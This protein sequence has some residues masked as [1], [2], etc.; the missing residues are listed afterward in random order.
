M[1][2]GGNSCLIYYTYELFGTLIYCVLS[3]PRPCMH[4]VHCSFCLFEN[5]DDDSKLS[6]LISHDGNLALCLC[7]FFIRYIFKEAPSAPPLL[8]ALLLLFRSLPS[9][10]SLWWSDSRQKGRKEKKEG[11][12]YGKE[13]EQVEME[14]SLQQSGSGLVGLQKVGSSSGRARA[15]RLFI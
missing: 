10:L 5:W 1:G 7:P 2:E 9:S 14:S 12:K 8:P 3:S 15:T 6:L 11:R 4:T 13:K